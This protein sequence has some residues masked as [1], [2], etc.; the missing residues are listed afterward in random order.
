MY[1][2]IPFLI[3]SGIVLVMSAPY[4]LISLQVKTMCLPIHVEASLTTTLFMVYYHSSS[5]PRALV[6]SSP[7]YVS[8]YQPLPSHS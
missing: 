8:T 2:F 7:T 3:V 4:S 5:V 1:S 6:V